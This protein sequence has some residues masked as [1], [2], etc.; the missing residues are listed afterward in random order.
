MNYDKKMSTKALVLLFLGASILGFGPILVRGA[1]EA[2]AEVIAFYRMLFA[3]PILFFISMR[4]PF[5]GETRAKLMA[6]SAGVFLSADLACWHTAIQTTKVANATL[7]IGLAP[8]WVA[9]MSSLYPG[10]RLSTRFFVALILC[11]SGMSMLT[12]MT[13]FLPTLGKGEYLSII[14]SIFYAAFTYLF[15]MVCKKMAP[16]HALKW[17]TFGS[18]IF[19][20]IVAL[21]RGAPLINFQQETWLSLLGLGVVIQSLAWFIISSSLKHLHATVGSLGLL[22]QQLATVVLGWI[23]LGEKLGKAQLLGCLIMIVG[24]GLGG[25]WA[26]KPAEITKELS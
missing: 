25:L 2:S 7:L 20:F 22:A 1:H 21:L 10:L 13:G 12:S 23:I 19:M 24:M 11:F 14:A 9:F 16:I 4:D 8:F 6:F 26:P 5:V 15:A 17:S 18:A 3:L